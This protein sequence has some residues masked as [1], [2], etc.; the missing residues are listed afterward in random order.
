M[1]LNCKTT[2]ILAVSAMRNHTPSGHHEHMGFA[3]RQRLTSTY[4]I[5][6]AWNA[7]SGENISRTRVWQILKRAERKL[8]ERLADLEHLCEGP[9]LPPE[10]GFQ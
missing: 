1:A 6:E 4:D 3:H 9:E 8:R 10:K 7:M 5:A 2:R